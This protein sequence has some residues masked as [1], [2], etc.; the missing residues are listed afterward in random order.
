MTD[1]QACCDRVRQSFSGMASKD[2][3]EEILELARRVDDG[4][5]ARRGVDPAEAMALARA[6]VAFQQRIAH[7]ASLPPTGAS[8]PPTVAPDVVVQV[9]EVATETPDTGSEQTGGA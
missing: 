5:A 6:V 2:P 1:E 3:W 8:L 4:V 7:G 9:A